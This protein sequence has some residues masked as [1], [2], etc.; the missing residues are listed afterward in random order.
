MCTHALSLA[1]GRQGALG[2]LDLGELDL[3][4]AAADEAGHDL[5]AGEAPLGE[6]GGEDLCGALALVEALDELGALGVAAADVEGPAD[7][8]AVLVL[9]E[10]DLVVGVLGDAVLEALG[11]FRC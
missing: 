6:L 7:E 10:L 3:G 4:G 8:G 5:A 2:G 1:L 11:R 9:V